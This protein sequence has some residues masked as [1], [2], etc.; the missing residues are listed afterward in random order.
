[1][2]EIESRT[3]RKTRPSFVW[4]IMLITVGVIF[5]L[6]NLGLVKDDFLIIIWR[7]WPVIFII[8]GLDSLL[9]RNEIAGPVFMIGLGLIILLS[10]IGWV[11]WRFWDILWR[12][13]PILLVAIGLE[14]IT[15]RRHLWVSIVIVSM[16]VAALCGVLWVFGRG[17]FGAEAL[18]ISTISHPLGEIHDAD[19]SISPVVGELTIDGFVD[20]NTLITGKLNDDGSQGVYSDYSVSSKSGI[21]SI[22]SRSFINFPGTQSWDWDFSLTDQIPLALDLEMGV[23][24][25]SVD[26]SNLILQSLEI[27]QAIGELNL[28]LAEGDDYRAELSQAIGSIIIELPED[29]GVRIEISRAISTLSLPSSFEHRGG[30]YYSSNYDTSDF[31]IDLE[32]NQAIGSIE[33]R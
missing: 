21:F 30:Y 33:I 11:E 8:I 27:N 15:G 31:K 1:M 17:Q 25:M 2:S 7:I 16:M 24:D 20:T 18:G 19:V 22:D 9:R 29:C 13:W 26:L 3:K 5:L 4:P 23:G 32:V 10:S 6:S 12:L 28:T 14:I